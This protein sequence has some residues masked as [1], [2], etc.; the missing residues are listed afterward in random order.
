[1]IRSV[2]RKSAVSAGIGQRPLTPVVL[3]ELLDV[4]A[5]ATVF[6]VV[7]RTIRRWINAGDLPAHRIGRSVRV[8]SEAI[9]AVLSKSLIVRS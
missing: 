4:A 2:A 5:A 9:K 6:G 8:S 1:M 3:P 7:P